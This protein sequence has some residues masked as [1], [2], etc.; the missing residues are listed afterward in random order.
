M[1]RVFF[2][3]SCSRAASSFCRRIVA[4]KGA[5]QLSFAVNVPSA[6]T[7]L[8]AAVQLGALFSPT[9]FLGSGQVEGLESSGSGVSL[10]LSSRRVRR[11]QL[12]FL[13]SGILWYT[14]GRRLVREVSIHQ[15]DQP[16]SNISETF[17]QCA[18]RWFVF[19][20]VR[21]NDTL[22]SLDEVVY[23][24]VDWLRCIAATRPRDKTGKSIYE[25]GCG[26]V[27][28]L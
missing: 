15:N 1:G 25:V 8:H 19:Q 12:F 13:R 27:R 10:G 11:A 3:S 7:K 14:S 16:I 23:D 4:G 28:V 26:G 18:N 6:G 5:A 17:L 20:Q 2:S 21:Q 24:G 22:C 9:W